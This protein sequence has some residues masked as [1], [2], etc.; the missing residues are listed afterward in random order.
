LSR[1]S[2]FP[3]IDVVLFFFLSMLVR[4]A[5]AVRVP[6][7]EGSTAAAVEISS[8]KSQT[9]VE[10][11]YC[12]TTGNGTIGYG[13]VIRG[14]VK[15]ISSAR[16]AEAQVIPDS[17]DDCGIVMAPYT[18]TQV[19]GHRWGTGSAYR[20]Y[21]CKFKQ[22]TKEQD[23]M[24]ASCKPPE[25]S[26]LMSAGT[27]CKMQARRCSWTYSKGNQTKKLD[28]WFMPHTPTK[29]EKLLDRMHFDEIPFYS[30]SWFDHHKV[31]T[32]YKDGALFCESVSESDAA[33]YNMEGWK[34]SAVQFKGDFNCGDQVPHEFDKGKCG[35]CMIS[36][37]GVFPGYPQC[38]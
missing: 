17:Q 14:F 3:V 10:K 9:V 4:M 23:F 6:S 20:Y 32:I 15:D 35:G 27:V 8:D 26:S 30:E 29:E 13:V 16:C 24:D 34:I 25:E 5:N 21:W 2:A 7:D 12:V 1:T 37:A 38:P 33:S 19:I 31:S 36:K 22:G 18:G 28:G 11:P